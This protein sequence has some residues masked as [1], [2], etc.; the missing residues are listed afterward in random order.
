MLV[1]SVISILV[2]NFTYQPEPNVQWKPIDSIV[3]MT[4]RVPI[5]W[6]FSFMTPFGWANIFFLLISLITKWPYMLVGSA[7]ATLL[8]GAWWPVIHVTMTGL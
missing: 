1:T 4:F 7:I 6:L 5:G 2:W 3:D 8:L